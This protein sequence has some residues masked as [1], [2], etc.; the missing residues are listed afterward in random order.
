MSKTTIEWVGDSWGY[1]QGCSPK[2]PGCARCYAEKIAKRLAKNPKVPQY[3]EEIA[4]WD[5]TL[6]FHV[7]GLIEPLLSKPTTWFPSM[8]DP[9]HEE[10][11]DDWIAMAFLT[12]ALCPLHRFLMLTKRPECALRWLDSP[13]RSSVQSAIKYKDSHISL[14][15][16]ITD[17]S[18][19]PGQHF[20]VINEAIDKYKVGGKLDGKQCDQFPLPNMMLGASVEDQI[21]ADERMPMMHQLKRQGWHTFISAEPLLGDVNLHLDKYPV[22]WVIIGGES[23]HKARQ[24]NLNWGRS[25]L[26]QCREHGVKAFFKQMG[27]NPV[28]SAPYIAGTGAESTNWQVEFEDKKGGNP[29][30]WAREFQVREQPEILQI[31]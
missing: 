1:Q 28:D 18:L 7:M 4:A 23:G 3:T 26:H 31:G 2:S 24:F 25:I 20:E 16:L 13:L 12:A 6:N 10:S 30:E 21:R 11:P 14:I 27:A 15:N 22:D 19:P 29:E 9:F 8:T 5:G 17:L